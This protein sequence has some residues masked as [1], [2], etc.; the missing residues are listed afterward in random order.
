M[1]MDLIKTFKKEISVFLYRAIGY[2]W[3]NIWIFYKKYL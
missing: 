1:I 2:F 3:I